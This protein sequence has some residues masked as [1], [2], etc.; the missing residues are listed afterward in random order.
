MVDTLR[1]FVTLPVPDWL[2][3]SMQPALV[4][5]AL[6][7]H[8]PEF[9]SGELVL[10]DCKVRRLRLKGDNN[11]W[12]G[13]YQ[14]TV[15]GANGEP[16][17]TV[18]VRGTL[19]PPG[20]IEPDYAI[21]HA[22]G[23]E[24]WRC[25]LPEVRLEFE[26][27]QPEAELAALPTLTDPE[28]ARVLLERSIRAGSEAYRNLRIQACTPQVMRHKPGSR[29]TVLYHLEYPAE[30]V[31]PRAW[32]E[33]VVAKTYIGDK[34]QNA[35]HSMRALWDSSMATSST[36]AIAEPLAYLPEMK[37]LVQGPIR[38]EQTLKTLIRAALSSGTPEAMGDL[39][40]YTRKTAAGLAALHRSGVHYGEEITWEDELA[41]IREVSERLGTAIPQLAGAAEPLLAR[42][43]ALAAEYP[44]DPLGP[45]HRSFRPAQVLLHKGQVGFIDFDG[46][47]QAE[48][49]M[50]LALFMTAIKSIGLSKAKG[51]EDD[52]GIDPEMR[53]Q[54]ITQLEALCETFLNGY[55]ALA[56]VSRQRI[57]LWESL[58]LLG[59]VMG[60][61]TKIKPGRL[62]N[63]MFV[64]ER[65]VRVSGLDTGLVSSR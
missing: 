41:E 12:S 5:S 64:L 60:S 58:D 27:Q 14:L 32:P 13:V 45:A 49:A 46:F 23:S 4:H 52:E 50:D 31:P 29:C 1:R 26:I 59:L 24:D 47:C 63:M 2:T 55:A 3:A 18:G 65:H 48:P 10:K 43:E 16:C 9:A 57:T 21:T 34:G 42:L 30:P 44:A 38:E 7:R 15:G 22:F 35:Y 53:L 33:I 39:H 19:I 6:V 51:D 25:Y 20:A 28:E 54:R 11:R 17:E 8:V 40:D 36:V 61:W 56:P 62:D 37:V